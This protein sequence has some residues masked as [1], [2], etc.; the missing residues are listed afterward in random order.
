MNVKNS[1]KYLIFL[2]IIV[3]GIFMIIYNPLLHG[4]LP[5]FNDI[6]ADTYNQNY[7]TNIY[8]RSQLS[9]GNI[10]NYDLN[11]GLGTNSFNLLY[12]N[13]FQLIYYFVPTAYMGLAMA[14]GSYLCV[15]FSAIFSFYIFK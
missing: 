4:Y 9:H 10:F 15:L 6:G 7:V 12:L 14:F 1:K 11:Y 2:I 5:I 3:T 13:L 8:I